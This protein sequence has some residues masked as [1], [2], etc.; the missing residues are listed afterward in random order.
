MLLS[1]VSVCAFAQFE[2]AA[3]SIGSSAIHKDSSIIVEW[4]TKCTIQRGY[5]N[6]LDT[7]KYFT[8]SEITS[9]K[10]FFGDQNYCIGNPKSI[11]N[12]VSL[13]DS[14]IAILEFE[15][16]ITNKS[17]YDFAIFENGLKSQFSPFQYFLELAFVEVSSDGLNYVRFPATSLTQNPINTYG[18][19]TPEKINNLA[20]KYILDYGTPFDL[21]DLKDS[22]NIDIE[23]IKY[24]KIID[25]VGCDNE[26]FCSYDILGN[27]IY[28]PYP[29][30]FWTCGFDL[31]GV[32]I[33]NSKQSIISASLINIYPNPTNDFLYFNTNDIFDI[34]IY[35]IMGKLVLNQKT[36]IGKNKIDVNN[37]KSGIYIIKSNN[38]ENYKFVKN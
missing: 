38:N 21:E 32:G 16:L 15:N 12:V 10:A 29:T 17:G 25:V 3:N 24:I 1:I 19:I 36:I 28:D 27:K 33:I 31:A 30:P 9:N 26:K 5:I 20:G 2:P 7:S 34:K 13:G 22:L 18:Q 37:L 14:G 35:D 4:A 23:N 8:Q 11:D 6:I